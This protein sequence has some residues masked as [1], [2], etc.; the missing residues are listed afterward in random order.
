MVAN[1]DARAALDRATNAVRSVA[2]AVQS[3][4]TS[5]T[6]A[7][8]DSR[9]PGGVLNQVTR[10]VREAPLRSLALAFLTGWIVARRV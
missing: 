9:Q 4:T 8:E 10:R 5:F 3:T 2:E 6:V 1:D 7:I